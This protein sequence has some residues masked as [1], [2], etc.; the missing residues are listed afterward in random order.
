MSPAPRRSH[1]RLTLALAT[2]IEAQIEEADGDCEVNI[3]PFDVRLP[4]SSDADGDGD[5][6]T[7]V[8]PDLVVICDESKLDDRG[9]RGAPDWI[10]EVLS[11]STASHDQIRKR[12]L[13]EAHGVREYWLVHPQDR[14]ALI[15]R[16]DDGAEYGAPEIVECTGTRAV[17]AVEGLTIDWDRA[18]ARVPRE[19]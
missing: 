16:L 18:F 8:Q 12:E 2:Q 7:V 5:E 3:A 17:R 1:Q 14:V 11:P 15:Y 4:A 9:A 10:V 13:Y 19:L 6:D